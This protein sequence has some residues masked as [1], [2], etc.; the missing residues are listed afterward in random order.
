MDV[1]QTDRSRNSAAGSPVVVHAAIP[2][3]LM[4]KWQ[5]IVDLIAEI[6]EVPASLIMKVEPPNITVLVSSESKDNPYERGD[7][8]LLDTGLYCDAVMETRQ[9]LLVPNATADPTWQSNPDIKL[10]MISYLG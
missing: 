3:D 4:R 5:E 10:G 2:A 6:V 1:R 8:A 7:K 9:R